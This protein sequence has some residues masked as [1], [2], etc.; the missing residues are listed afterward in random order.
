AGTLSLTNNNTYKGGTDVQAGTLSV[1]RAAS[2]GDGAVNLAGGS[3]LETQSSTTLTQN[4]LLKGDA[5]ISTGGIKPAENITQVTSTISGDGGLIKSGAGTLSLTNNNTYKGGTDVQAGTLS[6]ARAASLGDGAVNLA[7]GS[8]LETQ[9][10]TTLTQDI[11]LDGNATIKMGGQNAAQNITQITSAIT[12]KDQKNGNSSLTKSGAGTLSLTNNNTYKGGTDVQAGTLSVARAASLGDGAVTLQ[13]GSTLDTQASTTITQNVT[14][15][16]DATIST[17][18]AENITQIT[19]KIDGAG[20]L[21]KNGAGTLSLTAD[22]GYKGNTTI[23]QGTLAISRNDSLGTGT[24]VTINGATLKTNQDV[25]VGQD[26]T[27][28]GQGKIDTGGKNS[29]LSGMVTGGTLEKT[30]N[31]SLTL[32]DEANNQSNTILNGGILIIDDKDKD[33]VSTLGTGNLEIKKGTLQTSSDMVLNN[34]ITTT[35]SAGGSINTNGH[36]VTLNGQVTVKQIGVEVDTNGNPVLKDG[37]TIPVYGNGRLVKTGGGTLSLSNPNKDNDYN[38]GTGKDADGNTVAIIGNTVINGGVLAID[39]DKQ[40]GKQAE[41]LKEE[42]SEAK[43]QYSWKLG[44]VQID[45]GALKTESSVDSDRYVVIGN[46]GATVDV[47]GA[48]NTTTLSGLVDGKGALIKEGDG[49]L[50]LT[51]DVN[52]YKKDATTTADGFTKNT[53]ASVSVN[54]GV[55]EVDNTTKDFG[56]AVAVNLAG[57]ELRINQGASTGND[58]GVVTLQGTGGTLDTTG[59]TIRT[60]KITGDGSLQKQGSGTLVLTGSANDYKGDTTIS[61]GKVQID[62]AQGLG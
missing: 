58:L 29:I 31:G 50:K 40:L 61:E 45:G 12:E 9:S 10:S 22:N 46:A 27:I 21:T 47:S 59:A 30:G 1:A 53:L 15:S 13:T 16:G 14:L 23:N 17:T 35:S 18:G 42:I 36:D 37:S 6:V 8:T 5:T 43:D 55:L 24:L 39:N 62:S 54:A 38:I 57:G 51:L 3:T 25:N 7:D 28:I 11:T 4:I 20:S 19:S 52:N 56:G 2:L 48:A 49:T 32:N 26:V 34:K 33:N 60:A 44:N 41:K